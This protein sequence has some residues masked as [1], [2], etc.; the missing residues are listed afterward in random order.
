MNRFKTWLVTIV[1]LL[2]SITIS[3]FEVNGI[4]YNITSSRMVEVT[5]I[6]DNEYSGSITIPA[7]VTHEGVRYN[8]TSIG[9]AVFA[10]CSSIT[11][12]T[13]PE[14]VTSIGDWAFDGC[15]NLTAITIPENS[16]LTSIGRAAFCDCSSLTAI[17]IPEGVTSIG[18]SAFCD[19]SSL[20]SITIPEGVTSI[21][22]NTFDGCNSLK[23]ITLPESVTSIGDYAFYGCGDLTS[24][25]IPENSQ[26][27]SIGDYAFEVCESLTSITIPESV[28]SIGDCT[29]KNCYYLKSITIP[30]NSQLT[31]IG[32]A[33]FSRCF[34]LTS[35]TIPE[36][37]TSIGDWAFYDC[38]GLTSITI[39]E[40]VTSIGSST[41]DGCNSLKAI[42][43]PESVTSIGDDAFF[44]CSSLTSIT[45]PESVTSIGDNAFYNCSNLKTMVVKNV[46][47]P[48]LSYSLGVST[49]KVVVPGN[50]VEAYREADYWEKHNIVGLYTITYLVD[51]ETYEIVEVAHGDDITPIANPVKE[52]YTFGGWGEMPA[53]M[54]AENIIV[55]GGYIYTVTYMVDGETYE[56]VKVAYGDVLTPPI[57]EGHTLVDWSEAPETMP[58]ED[59]II[60]VTFTANNYN[61]IYKIDDAVYKTEQVVYGSDIVLTDDVPTKEGHTFVEWVMPVSSGIEIAS[62]ADAMLYSN[63]PCTETRYGDQFVGW[64]VLFD[65]DVN[66][67]FHSDYSG[68]DSADGL[69]HYLRVD[70]GEDN[71]ISRFIFTYTVRG[72]Q[73]PWYTPVEMIVEGSNEADGEYDEIAVLTELPRDKGEV[74]ES[75]IL[76]NGNAYRYI[77]YRVTETMYNSMYH[78]HPYFYFAEFGMSRVD[79]ISVVVTMPAHDVVVNALLTKNKYK[80]TFKVGDEVLS[81]EM[82][83]Y[84]SRIIA[85]RPYKEG[86]TFGG[87]GD[88]A[89]TVPAHDVT[90]EGCYS[91]NSYILTYIVDGDVVKEVPVLYGTAITSLDNP[92][93]EGYTFSLSG[94]MPETMPAEDV[95]VYGTFTINKY[96]VTFALGGV[97]KKTEQLEY[98]A[99]IVVPTFTEREGYT[100]TWSE[101]I[102]ATVPAKDVYYN[103]VYVAN[104]YQVYYFVGTDLVHVADVPYGEKIPEYIY[105]P[106]E[107]EEVFLGWLGDEYETMPAHEIF[108]TAEM[109]PVGIEKLIG[110]GEQ[111]TVIYDLQGRRVLDTQNLKAGIYIVNGK[112][113]VLK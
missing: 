100:L 41:F 52:G 1:T 76:G 58:A 35:I 86:Y 113:V 60:N 23:A 95:T 44:G 31:S 66:T 88:V 22:S 34:C 51:G 78:G 96:R 11:T 112:K 92:A 56:T 46:V 38:S 17:N 63:A 108:L 42:T 8:V 28:T 102:P 54:P 65:N 37:V 19:C 47:P 55:S 43:L 24:I 39:P 87:W 67:F 7:T 75:D 101:E 81:E 71:P 74:Y 94:E 16:Q 57:K 32:R 36:S 12:I 62:N 5:G 40:G 90:Y 98:G 25:T 50:S 9:Y 97:V 80:V 14:S 84:G 89:E 106:E 79:D 20:T 99:T 6:Y 105:E 30:E 49:M 107:G 91:V 64:H 48:A 3:A 59:I 53:T 10:G 83:E 110:N 33:A 27:T 85:P 61:L 15:S 26:L 29:F 18:S 77:R 70:M 82:L 103:A 69:D 104:I 72:D 2:C 4:Y 13:I 21:G 68:D 73:T 111:K 45:L 93:K 109:V